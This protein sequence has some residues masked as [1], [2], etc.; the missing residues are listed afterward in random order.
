M[1]PTVAPT[2]NSGRE[3]LLVD[4]ELEGRR[5]ESR[6]IARHHEDEAEERREGGDQSDD[7]GELDEPPS[8]GIVIFII[9][10]N[11]PAPST[12]AAS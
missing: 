5:G 4:K 3:R 2:P 6:I 7:E 12:R 11:E 8:S 9:T 10:V 1:T